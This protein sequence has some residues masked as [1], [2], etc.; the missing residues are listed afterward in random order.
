V[1]A[2]EHDIPFYVAAPRSTFDLNQTSEDVVLEERNPEEVTH[3]GHQRIAPSGIDVL[4][5]AFDITPMKY[6]DAIIC[7]TGVFSPNEL[8]KSM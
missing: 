2:H 1:L 6:V 3:F 8:E 5:P 4:N 7:E